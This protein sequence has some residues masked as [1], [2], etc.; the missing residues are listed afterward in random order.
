MSVSNR[1]KLLIALKKYIN[2]GMH[3]ELTS[4]YVAGLVMYMSMT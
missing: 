4:F 2:H 1:E 3:V